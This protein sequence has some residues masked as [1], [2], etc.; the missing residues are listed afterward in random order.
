MYG[1]NR[2][3][4]AKVINWPLPL[5]G[6]VLSL[7]LAWG[8]GWL[9]ARE[10][11]QREYAP[12]S[13]S[14]AAK[15]DAKSACVGT[16]PGAVF[17]CVNEKAKTAYQTAHDEQDLSAQQRAA[18]SALITAV[19]SALALALSGVGVW[20]VK[21]TLDATLKAVEHNGKAT[22]AMDESNSIA[23]VGS[24]PYIIVN[25]PSHNSQQWRHEYAIFTWK[26]RFGNY[27]KSP[28][29][30]EEFLCLA[31][32][33]ETVESILWFPGLRPTDSMSGVILSSDQIETH[34]QAT[35]SPMHQRMDHAALAKAPKPLLDWERDIYPQL[36]KP[37][38][39]PDQH[40]VF[41]LIGV[42]RYSSPHGEKHETGFCFRGAAGLK[43]EI[44][45][46]GCEA[47][48]YRT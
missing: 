8:V 10:E 41:W 6:I 19:L 35:Q 28:A 42:I 40:N 12:K 11:Y 33:G 38:S 27:G 16:E 48:N 18:S 32:V 2:S 5:A 26:F 30:I 7:S 24:R 3:E 25:K 21:R 22:V 44:D 31:G 45:Q 20:Y 47:Y 14:A 4:N 36:I 13:Y 43:G 17:E 29:I 34:F 39:H 15:Q 46:Q 23:R 37:L 9:E 1:S